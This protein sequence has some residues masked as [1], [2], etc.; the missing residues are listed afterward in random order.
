MKNVRMV[1]GPAHGRE[2]VV[3]DDVKHI[4]IPVEVTSE[5]FVEVRYT[6]RELIAPGAES[7][8]YAFVGGLTLNEGM[9]MIAAAWPN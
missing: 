8:F 3:E 9:A 2:I 7:R 4:S 6:I 1:G 5:G